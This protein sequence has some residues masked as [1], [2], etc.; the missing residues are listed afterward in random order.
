MVDKNKVKH[1]KVQGLGFRASPTKRRRS[2]RD[3]ATRLES[4]GGDIST[5]CCSQTRGARLFGLCVIAI[6]PTRGSL[7]RNHPTYYL[8]KFSGTLPPMSHAQDIAHR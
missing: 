4:G 8:L 7:A 2:I 3:G 5:S 6:H 1:F